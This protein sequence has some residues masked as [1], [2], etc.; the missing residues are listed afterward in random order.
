V[1]EDIIVE[2]EIQTLNSSL[3]QLVVCEPIIKLFDK[4]IKKYLS[5]RSPKHG[6]TDK[7]NVDEGPKG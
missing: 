3:I 5:Y 4:K 6:T 2:A 1:I 7:K